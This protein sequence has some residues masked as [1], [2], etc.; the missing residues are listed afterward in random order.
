[1]IWLNTFLIA[2]LSAALGGFAGGLVAT[3]GVKWYRIS[4]FEGG[5]GYFVVFMGLLGIVAG[6]LI[7]IVTAL[8]VW[9]DSGGGFLKVLGL[10]W[11]IILLTGG[12]IA[13]VSRLLADVP[14]T[15]DGQEL[16][17]VVDVRWPADQTASPAEVASG[18][19]HLVLGSLAG[20]VLR[21]SERGILWT[22]EAV[23]VDGRWIARGVANVFTSRGRRT[24]A[25]NTGP[26]L[27]ESFLV[28]LPAFPRG[29]SR[30]W[31]DWLPRS[32]ATGP[33]SRLTYRFRVQRWS[34]PTKAETVG[35]FEIAT[36][37]R[38]VFESS[39]RGRQVVDSDDRFRIAHRGRPVRFD[40]A[41]DNP[42]DQ[43]RANML[44]TFPG[45]PTTLLV[46]VSR[47]YDP[48]KMYLV[49]DDG[50]TA[51]VEFVAD[52]TPIPSLIF[53]G[54]GTAGDD[55]GIK[56]NRRRIDRDGIYHV[57]P[58]GVLDSRSMTAYRYSSPPDQIETGDFKPLM[59]SPDERSF[60]RVTLT[61]QVVLKP[62]LTAT[63][64]VADRSD[65]LPIDPRR[66]RFTRTEQIDLAW[67][68]HHFQWERDA[69]GIDR[70]VERKDFALLPF[71]GEL[72]P[73]TMA[74]PVYHVNRVTAG[75]WAILDGLLVS[76]SNAVAKIVE[77]S[78]DH[79]FLLDGVKITTC[80]I[81]GSKYVMVGL[82]AAM[83]VAR[84][85]EI[86]AAFDAELATGKYD[87]LF[88]D[89]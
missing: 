87:A 79:E 69:A 41:G 75:M 26:G 13:A 18:D 35:P 39:D 16:L 62:N 52:S 84:V 17:L 24:L 46:S 44:A 27:T 63:D 25:I 33:S 22:G 23:Q 10:A 54:P 12:V 32:R 34:E 48:G 78:F 89:D 37:T 77:G 36:V 7:G 50:D 51:R 68:L 71:R 15:I 9:A 56:R 29:R 88:V 8:S 59:L 30:Q 21:K 55:S 74:R 20:R 83:P 19:A 86:V 53:I 40:D 5:A 73:D 81:E 66:M 60:V 61:N 49:H 47:Y 42:D 58:R 31:S 76:K 11:G 28:P 85:A 2:V 6:L 43:P 80:Y 14:P 65:L 57:A 67:V 82:D 70:L 45:K 72:I 64:F 3:G 4:K 1:V 38:K